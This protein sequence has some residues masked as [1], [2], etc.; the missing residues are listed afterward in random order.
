MPEVWGGG[1]AGSPALT[2]DDLLAS[3]FSPYRGLHALAHLPA[4]PRLLAVDVHETPSGYTFLCDVP[5]IPQENVKISLVP[6]ERLISISA[7]RSMQTEGPQHRQERYYGMTTRSFRLPANTDMEHVAA[8]AEHGVLN[9]TLPKTSESH[10]GVRKVPIEWRSA[11]VE[12]EEVPPAGA[13][14]ADAA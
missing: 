1:S 7:E 14:P 13:S 10:E 8:T 3:A 12:K 9:I 5:G 4:P 2:V 11:E 6:E